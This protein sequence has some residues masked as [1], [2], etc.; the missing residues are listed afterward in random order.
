MEATMP[1]EIRDNRFTLNAVENI[2]RL[3]REIRQ[4]FLPQLENT[5]EMRLS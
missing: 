1:L 2:E 4:T 3:L 5:K